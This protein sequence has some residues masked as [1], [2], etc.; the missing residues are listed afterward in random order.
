MK[1]PLNILICT[2]IIFACLFVP[3]DASDLGLTP[4]PFWPPAKILQ[5][6]C[7]QAKVNKE[8]WGITCAVTQDAMHLGLYEAFEDSDRR[9]LS[10]YHQSRLALQYKMMGGTDMS[11]DEN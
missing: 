2:A 10:L 5:Y 1:K 9:A 6:E 8:E 7:T 3:A 4:S 11:K